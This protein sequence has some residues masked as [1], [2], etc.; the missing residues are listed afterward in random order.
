MKQ[1]NAEGVTI[2]L[3]EQMATMALSVAHRA[4]VIQNGRVVVEGP[5]ARVAADPEVV[6]AYLGGAPRTDLRSTSTPALVTALLVRHPS[7]REL[8]QMDKVILAYSGGLDTSV[9]IKWLHET[10]NL[11]VICVTVD[12]GNERDFESIQEKALRTGAV[13]AYVHDA[14]D[15][16]VNFFVFPSLQAGTIYEGQYPLATALARPLIAK[17]MVDYARAGGRDRR[18]AR[19]HRQGQRPG[20][21]RRLVQGAG[22]G[23]EDRRARPRVA[24]D[25]RGGDPLRPE[26]RHSRPVDGRQPVQHRPEPLG[27]QHRGRRARRPVGRAARGRLRLDDERR[28]TRPTSRATSRSSSSRASRSRSTAS[29]S[30]ARR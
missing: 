2:L 7:A 9:A 26:A 24:L 20:P 27:P 15:D 6:R 18:R 11:E 3:V 13:K 30:T 22:A 21:L 4:Y 19:L 14:K 28:A 16:F 29:T 8:E 23:P 12:V 17:I 25:P 5:S 10:Y 1:L